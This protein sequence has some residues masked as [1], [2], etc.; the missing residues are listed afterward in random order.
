[1]PV[2]ARMP[3]LRDNRG[4]RYNRAAMSGTFEAAYL[5]L[6]EEE[7]RRRAEQALQGLADCR[8]CARECGVN[9]L[10]GELGSCNT[11]RR[12]R[13]SSAF[14]HFGEERPLVGMHGSGTIFF[15]WCNLH[16]VFC[17]NHDISQGGQ[18][19]ECDA[20]T[21]GRAMIELQRMGCHNIN[22]VSPSH[23][24]AQ[25][26]EALAL[27]AQWGLRVPLVYNTGTYDSLETLKLLDG[28]VD[29]YMPD[30]KYGCEK[31]AKKYSDAPGYPE[32]MKA[33]LK[34]M[35]RQVGDLVV[36]EHG[37]AKRGVL[38]RHLV[39]PNG[40][41][42]SRRVLEFIAKELG[43]NTYINIMGQY[44]PQHRA[45]EYEELARRPS[46]REMEEVVRVAGELGL[47]RLDE[48]WLLA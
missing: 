42:G 18:G 29:I 10:K 39:M 17:Q 20:E 2:A 23:V 45:M 26:L 30:T 21:I 37:V 32:V 41:A 13:V 22:F 43:P 15:S 31:N 47:K 5:R 14:P 28:I 48:R 6:G 19:Q 11:G 3:L 24:V 9:R 44:R 16:C 35:H 27:A 36:D 46:R 12:A 34:E 4:V 1:M 38:I 33:A 8:L 25:I 40:V 7:L